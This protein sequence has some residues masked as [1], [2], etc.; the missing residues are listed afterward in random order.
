MKPLLATYIFVMLLSNVLFA[1]QVS[2]LHKDLAADSV[3]GIS[4]EK[5]YS[6]I[7]KGRKSSKVIVAVIDSGIDTLHEDL[8][9]VLWKDSKTGLCGWNYIGNET[10]REDITLLVG[11]K[12]EFYDSLSFTSVPEVYRAGYQQFKKLEPTLAT[13]C[14]VMR[15]FIRKLEKSKRLA[16]QIESQLGKPAPVINDFRTYVPKD[17]EERNLIE[18]IIDRF[19]L[20]KNWEELKFAEIDNLISLANYHLQHGLNADN[21]EAD[22]AKGDR[23]IYPDAIGLISQANETSNHGTHVAAIIGAVRGNGIGID[24]I[25]DKVSLMMLKTNGNIREL[26]DRNLA[27]AICFAVDHGA[28]VINL[29]FGKPYS[30]DKNAVDAAIAYATSKDVLLV[31]SAGNNGDNLENVKFF[32]NPTNKRNW[33]EVGASGPKDDKS[34]AAD[35]SNY[36]ESI[37]DVFAP[38]VGIYSCITGSKY[39]CMSGTSMAAPVVAG[40]AALIREYFP[41]L[42][43]W[44]VKE[45]ICKSVVRRDVLKEKCITGGVVNAYD[46]IKLATVYK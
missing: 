8:Q 13:K 31:H 42:K 28:K 23:N 7:L 43:A 9:S 25:A 1:Q 37:V 5:A 18:V 22:N 41:K 24:G 12:K 46:A 32:P 4:S 19:P 17:N 39:E 10:G 44:Q 14:A 15:D 33:I 38:G 30:Y 36:G 2:W 21:K 34:L 20:Y 6:S 27:K 35:F 40:I 16:E 45:V 3:F 26:R 11:D 29:S